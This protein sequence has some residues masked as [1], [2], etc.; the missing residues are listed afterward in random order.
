MFTN[1]KD[2]LGRRSEL[3]TVCNDLGGWCMYVCLLECGV[4]IVCE[5]EGHAPVAINHDPLPAASWV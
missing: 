5:I 1:N 3:G 2:A 4:E